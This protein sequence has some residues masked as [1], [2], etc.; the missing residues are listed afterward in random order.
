MLEITLEK[1]RNSDQ[2]TDEMVEKLLNK[3]GV[4]MTDLDGMQMV[5][6]MKPKTLNVWC[7]AGVDLTSDQV[8]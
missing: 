2:I 1:E 8:L 4:K 6:K 7:K 5:P 3:M